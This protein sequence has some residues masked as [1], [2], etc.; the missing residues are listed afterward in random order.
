MA[1]YERTYKRYAG[2]LTA[3]WSRFLV[4]PRYAF[5]DVFR[6]KLFVAFFALS[7]VA[8]LMFGALIYVRHNAGFLEAFPDFDLDQIMP[9]DALYF[10]RL[11]KTQFWFGFCLAIFIGPGLV[12]RDLANNGLPLYLS[13]PFSRAEYVLGKFS[14]LALLISAITWGAGLTLFLLQSNLA[15]LGWMKEN[16]RIGTAIFV[17]SWVWIAM[18]SLLALALSAW[19]KWRPVAGFMMLLVFLTGSFFH[20]MINGLFRVEWGGLVNLGSVAY[21]VFEGLM[22]LERRGGTPVAGAWVSAMLFTACCLFLL[23]RKVRAYEV[24]R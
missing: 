8:P 3:A 4:L 11:M 22:G 2:G 10:S 23:H 18:F 17:G 14:V 1:V 12:S 20:V 24:V 19:V 9:I 6:S 13:R 5:Q 21:A 16:L 7:F 15:G